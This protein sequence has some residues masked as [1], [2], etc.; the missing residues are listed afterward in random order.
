MDES[1]VTYDLW[2]EIDLHHSRSE[3]MKAFLLYRKATNC[4]IAEG[5]NVIGERF[6]ERFPEL[7][8]VYRNLDDDD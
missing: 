3:V 2:E 7:W 4:S 5:K 8:A 1:L 6:H